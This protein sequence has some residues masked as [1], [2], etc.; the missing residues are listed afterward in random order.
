MKKYFLNLLLVISVV[1]ISS[2]G[3]TETSVET[4]IAETVSDIKTEEEMKKLPVKQKVDKEFNAVFNEVIDTVNPGT[5]GSSLK[6][7]KAAAMFLD[8]CEG[9]EN[10]LSEVDP[11]IKGLSD[12]K[13]EDLVEK[14]ID[15]SSTM[16][17]AKK[18]D[19]KE[20]LSDAGVT[21][22][23]HPWSDKAFETATTTIMYMG[24]CLN[25]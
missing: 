25:N 17:L 21:D 13:K 23:K 11:Y 2:C 14:L 15:L 18:D 7:A 10:L 4:K 6:A 3:K 20:L 8:Y 12:K 19:F 22:S 1:V 5:A 16:E 24:M 9:K